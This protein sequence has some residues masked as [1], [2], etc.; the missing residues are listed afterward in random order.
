MDRN[1]MENSKYRA[2]VQ[3]AT[4][5]K[6]MMKMANEI[7]KKKKHEN[8]KNKTSVMLRGRDAQS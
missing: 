6:L 7:K 3:M 4:A 5:C 1:E 8:R 2:S